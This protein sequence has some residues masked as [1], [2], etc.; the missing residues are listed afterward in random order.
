[1]FF[2][3]VFGGCKSDYPTLASDSAVEMVY[4]AVVS[5]NPRFVRI[6]VVEFFRRNNKR[7]AV[8]VC[9]MNKVGGTRESFDCRFREIF[10][11]GV[12]VKHD[13]DVAQTHNLRVAGKAFAR[14]YNRF[15][16]ES[17]P[18]LHIVGERH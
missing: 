8:P 11:E 1:M 10:A 6:D 12:E 7:H 17:A 9:P 16:A 4:Y 5:Y 14:I 18:R 2:G 15:L 13:I 3:K